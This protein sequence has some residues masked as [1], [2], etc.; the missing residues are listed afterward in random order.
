MKIIIDRTKWI[1]NQLCKETDEGMKY[2]ALGYLA[3][4]EGHKPQDVLR[5]G[6]GCNSQ[7]LGTLDAKYTWAWTGFVSM[8]NDSSRSMK[9]KETLLIELFAKK[10]LE[11]EFI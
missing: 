3:L 1:T 5:G 8:A 4:A 10:D 9:E 7:I 6:H 2:C 11:L